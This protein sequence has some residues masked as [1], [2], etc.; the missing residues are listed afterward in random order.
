MYKKAIIFILCLGMLMQSVPIATIAEETTNSDN[1]IEKYETIIDEDIIDVSGYTSVSIQTVNDML[2]QYKFSARQGHGFAA[3]RGNNLADKIKG[4]NTIVVGDNNVKNGADRLIIERN[5]TKIW[6]QDKYYADAKAGINACFDET[7][8]FRYIDGDGNPMQIE[9]PYDQ[10]AEAVECMKAKIEEGKVQGITD[11]SEAETLVRKGALTYKQAQ[12]LAKAGTVES[13]TYDATNGVVSATC[14]MGISILINYTVCRIN[15]DTKEEAAHTAAEEGLKTGGLAFCSAVIAGQLAK[16]GAV[17]IFAPSSEALVKALGEDF[18][19][20]LIQSTGKE[21]GE[22][23]AQAATKQ[24]AKVLRSQ[25]LVAV[26]T[27]V[28]FTVPDAID[29]FNGRISKTQFVKN[30]SVTA[31]SV[32]MG[33]A[34]SIG[35][36]ALGSAIAPGVGTAVGG[37]VGGLVGGFAGGLGADAIADNIVEDDAEKMYAIVQ[38]TFAQKCEDY[39][40][41]EAEAQIIVEQLKDM[42]DE[43]MYKDMYQ[44]ENREEFI[45]EKLDPLFVQEME[46]RPEIEEPTEEEMREILKEEL[47][48]VVFI[49]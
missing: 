9:V 28:V 34:G 44:S 39:L 43:D 26:V 16:T 27:T 45:D 21:V 38:N 12:N 8:M 11:P 22:M 20:A 47:Y 23:S 37:V 4:K 36:S 17:D 42:L 1:T 19:K 2:E 30:F 35:C 25:T 33:T 6:I 5:G 18:A 15:G 3:E 41:T 32:V 29:L 14:A 13:L 40:V 46:K 31:A 10:Y 49:H 24:A 48:E 7:G